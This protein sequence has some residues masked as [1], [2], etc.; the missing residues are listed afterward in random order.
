VDFFNG[1]TLLGTATNNPFTFTWTNAVAGS[2]S[3]T[4]RA[5]DNGGGS[6][7]SSP[8]SVTVNSS[9]GGVPP[10]TIVASGS[11]IEIYWATAG[12]QLQMA[13]NLSSPKWV[14]VPNTLLT[15]R[16]TFTI[17]GDATF[18]RLSQQGTPAGPRLTIVFSGNSVVVSWPSQITSYRLQAKSDLNAAT[19]T[20]VATSNNQVTE[21][22]TGQA[23]FY[24]LSP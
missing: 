13:T 3:L 8:V 24:R 6:S 7:T 17:S 10:L 20:D 19:W 23:R 11:T 1:A 9:T 4:A 16:I 12:Y 5:T 21:T 15:N 2:Y 22:I 18:F 14:D